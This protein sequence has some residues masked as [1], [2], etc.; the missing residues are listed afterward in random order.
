MA[1]IFS[2]LTNF[3]SLKKRKVV[4]ETAQNKDA[5]QERIEMSEKHKLKIAQYN[6]LLDKLNHKME[7]DNDEKATAFYQKKKQIINQ[8]LEMLVIV[9][10]SIKTYGASIPSRSLETPAYHHRKFLKT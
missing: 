5:L 7:K 4:D 2:V 10:T 3:T 1:D 9:L 8:K 6:E